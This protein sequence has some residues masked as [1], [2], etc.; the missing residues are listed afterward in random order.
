LVFKLSFAQERARI[1]SFTQMQSPQLVD[2]LTKLLSSSKADSAR[3]LIIHQLCYPLLFSRPDSA[4]YYA[5]EG[6]K[7]ADSI[8]F[9]KGQV[10]CKS[11]IAAVWWIIGDYPKAKDLLHKVIREAEKLP[12]TE[13]LEWSLSFLISCYRDEGNLEEALQYG[14][15][16]A[17]IAQ[18]FT[19]P[20]WNVILGSVFHEM[21]QTESARYYLEKGDSD[22]YN[23][24]LLAHSYAK[25]GNNNRA[26]EYYKKAIDKFLILVNFKDLADSYIGL[27][28]IYE[29][30]NKLDTAI[31][32]AKMGFNISQEASFKKWVYVTGLILSRLYEKRDPREALTYF[33][34][35]MAAKDSIFNIQK[36]T[37]TLNARYQEQLREK[38]VE[39]ARLNYENRIRTYGLLA[40]VGFCLLVA[41]ILY[42]NNLQKQKAK[43][44]IEKAYG[45]LQST[46]AQLIQAEKMASLGALTAGIAHEI[47]N[48]LNFV[49]NF[50]EVNKELL[51]EMREEI[52]K[53]NFDEVSR[54]AENVEDNQDKINEHGK[55]AESIVKGMLLHSR[56]SSGA[57]ELVDINMQADEYLRLAYHGF[58]AKDKDFN[59]AIDTDFDPSVGSVK[60]VPQETGRVLL[61]LFNNA[62]YAVNERKGLRQNGYEPVV[63]VSTKRTVDKVMIAVQDNGNGIPQKV[64]DKIFQPFFTT[65]PTGQGTG[66]GLSLVYDIVKAH[67]G[68]IKVQTKE[69]EGTEFIVELPA[70]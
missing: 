27:A 23:L 63:S 20:I 41:A 18:F 28:R 69:G 13:A 40:V 46:Q 24:L 22:G 53:G 8:S 52:S 54:L 62:F 25:T 44:N 1:D 67:G 57:K 64:I 50:S 11:D 6:L 10:L 37:E 32:Y 34:L 38:E 33:K 70:T 43:A 5:Q 56:S 9:T 35:A 30:E 29:Q 65:K 17:A 14:Y 66:L 36:I 55:R 21:D 51:G 68:E 31:Y 45:E 48:P 58:R 19:K 2:S 61:N 4:M 7:L 16:G 12:D 47:Q 49:N 42:K 59:A 15:R 26:R 60:V 3:V 39:A